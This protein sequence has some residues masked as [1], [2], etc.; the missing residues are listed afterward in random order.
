MGTTLMMPNTLD[1]LNE[2]RVNYT[3]SLLFVEE[4]RDDVD[5]M[6]LCRYSSIYTVSVIWK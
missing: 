4:S 5:W 2:D 1:I 3:R 6:S